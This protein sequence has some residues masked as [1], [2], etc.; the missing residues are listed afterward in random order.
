[1]LSE[2]QFDFEPAHV[3]MEDQG[4]FTA[5]SVPP[6][7]N[8][9]LP[10]SAGVEMVVLSQ[11]DIPLA[12]KTRSISVPS[13][14]ISSPT[15]DGFQGQPDNPLILWSGEDNDGDQLHY[16]IQY[17]SSSNESNWVTLAIDLTDEELAVRLDSL[18]GG[19]TRVRVLATDGFNTGMAVSPAFSIANKA[20]EVAIL[21]PQED[22]ITIEP[23][24]R[25]VAMGTAFDREDGTLDPGNLSWHSDLDGFL[26]NGQ[27][28]DLAILSS[29]IH[30][31]VLK[32]EDSIGQIG[33][34]T[35][36]VEV[37]E[38]INTQ[39]IADAGPDQS[40]KVGQIIPLDGTGSSDEDSDP[41]F[42]YWS[43]VSQP[44]G[45]SPTLMGTDMAQPGFSTN[46]AGIYEIKLVVNDGQV[47][48]VPDIVRIDVTEF[49]K[50]ILGG[51]ENIGIS[52]PHATTIKRH[53]AGPIKA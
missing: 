31:I 29:G 15:S 14:V 20:P 47:G 18:P 43:I 40:I 52:L 37:S 25:V 11:D 53:R 32:G 41:L 42:Y 17:N 9:L 27:Q 35:F 39:P 26:G 5:I 3:D 49:E 16:L 36:V 12:E 33:E 44:P 4:I 38:W 2:V 34:D 48:S 23:R 51:P 21:S 10:L 28:I 6:T 50:T 7:F 46:M 30:E 45:S 8:Q 24:S 19:I 22:I 1:V 13:V